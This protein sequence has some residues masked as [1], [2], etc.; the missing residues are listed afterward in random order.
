TPPFSPLSLHDALPISQI[1]LV[2]SYGMVGNAGT[3]TSTTSPFTASSDQLRARVN[4]LS[5]LAGLQQLVAPPATTIS[6]ALIG[7]SGQSLRSEE[8]TSELQ[9]RFDLV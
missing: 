1:D 2:G 3:V 9:S 4:Q 5:L 6:P 7:A 8:H